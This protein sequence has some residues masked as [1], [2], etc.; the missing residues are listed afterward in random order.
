MNNRVV[1]C[2]LIVHKVFIY[3]YSHLLPPNPSRRTP[4]P[5][6]DF[7]RSPS[8]SRFLS[9]SGL[10]PPW[11][12]PSHR[13]GDPCFPPFLAS[14]TIVDSVCVCV[15]REGEKKSCVRGGRRS[16]RFPAKM[17]DTTSSLTLGNF[18]SFPFPSVLDYWEINF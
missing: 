6:F 10:P 4:S 3:I 11:S 12:P 18:S 2:N 5:F 9:S 14:R 7:D 15:W 13:R 17:E 8:P 1:N 16:R